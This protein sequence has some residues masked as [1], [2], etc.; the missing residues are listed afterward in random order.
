MPQRRARRCSFSE[1]FASFSITS[2]SQSASAIRIAFHEDTAVPLFDGDRNEPLLEARTE[3]APA[4][5]RRVGRAVRRAYQMQAPDIKKLAGHPV[6][7]HGHVGAAVQIG[8]NLSV[9]AHR[10]RRLPLPVELH[11]EAHS[12]PAIQELRA[13]ANYAFC[14]SH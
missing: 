1:A 12:V 3:Y 4:R 8:V 2:L 7:L 10:E 6:E 14:F 5:V 13:R 9:V 11:L